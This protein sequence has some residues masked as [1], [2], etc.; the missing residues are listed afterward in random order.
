[1]A[2][3]LGA[4][5]HARLLD[6]RTLESELVPLPEDVEIVVADT[7]VRRELASS[8][9]NVRRAQCEEAVEVLSEY[10]PGIRALRDVSS[11]ELEQHKE[12]LSEIV[13]RR[14]RHVVGDNERVLLAADALRDGDVGNVGALM[15]ACHI[16]L[17]DDYEVSSAELDVLV[18]AAWEVE[19]CYGARLTGA[20][21]GG[22]AV[23]L[24]A[25]DAVPDFE[26]HVA[27]AY[28]VAFDRPPDIYASRSANGVE[29][30][31]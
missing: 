3:A 25:E 8:E 6:C 14:A 23:A 17:R 19:G 28:E 20:G 2:S 9:Y 31:L 30:M 1:M 27:A 26:A 4:K 22:C 5:D 15:K 29:R 12:H 10:L 16:S 7:K 11:D 13:Y 18:E 21:F 24:V